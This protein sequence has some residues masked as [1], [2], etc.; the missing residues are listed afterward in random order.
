[1]CTSL[2]CIRMY[3]FFYQPIQSFWGYCLQRGNLYWSSGSAALAQRRRRERTSR[4]AWH[5]WVR[6]SRWRPSTRSSSA[7][8][9]ERAVSR[10]R[11]LGLTEWSLQ[12]LRSRISLHQLSTIKMRA[13]DLLIVQLQIEKVNQKFIFSEFVYRLIWNKST[14]LFKLNNFLKFW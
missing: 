11:R 2:Y 5:S 13:L 14:N 1:M 12:A 6:V 8:T 3:C 10:D 7:P 9:Q 4:A